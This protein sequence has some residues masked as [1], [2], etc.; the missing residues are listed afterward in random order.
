MLEASN[1]GRTH[2]S[3]APVVR[4]YFAAMF[5]LLFRCHCLHPPQGVGRVDLTRSGMRESHVANKD[6]SYEFLELAFLGVCG[7]FSRLD[8]LRQQCRPATFLLRSIVR[9]RCVR[10]MHYPGFEFAPRQ[11]FCWY[12]DCERDFLTLAGAPMR[13]LFLPSSCHI[14]GPLI[15]EATRYGVPGDDDTV[16]NSLANIVGGTGRAGTVLDHVAH[17]SSDENGC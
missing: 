17:N 16:S 13:C 1:N 8:Y 10:C 2:E 4:R 11:C 3:Q 12:F 14:F 6:G 7:G 5:M 9:S 15:W